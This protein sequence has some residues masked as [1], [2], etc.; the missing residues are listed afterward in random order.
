[1]KAAALLLSFVILADCATLRLE[2]PGRVPEDLPR[3]TWGCHRGHCATQCNLFQGVKM[4][5][6]T[7][8]IPL[9]EVVPSMDKI[10]SALARDDGRKED[11]EMGYSKKKLCTITPMIDP[12]HPD[13]GA[14]FNVK[15]VE[16][17]QSSRVSKNDLRLAST[18]C[19]DLGS[20]PN[21]LAEQAWKDTQCS[22]VEGENLCPVHQSKFKMVLRLLIRQKLNHE[23]LTLEERANLEVIS[24]E[25]TGQEG[26][27]PINKR[28]TLH[29]LADSLDNFWDDYSTVYPGKSLGTFMTENA[30]PDFKE[31]ANDVRPPPVIEDRSLDEEL[32]TRTPIDLASNV[33][34]DD[35]KRAYGEVPKKMHH[36]PALVFNRKPIGVYPLE[37]TIKVMR[38][39]VENGTQNWTETGPHLDKYLMFDREGC[40]LGERKQ[41]EE[42]DE[43]DKFVAAVLSNCT[44]WGGRR[45]RCLGNSMPL[46]V[47]G[48]NDIC[49][50]RDAEVI[51]VQQQYQDNLDMCMIYCR[52]TVGQ[53]REALR[54]LY[55]TVLYRTPFQNMDGPVTSEL[56]D[57]LAARERDSKNGRQAECWHESY[58]SYMHDTQKKVMRLAFANSEDWC[59]HDDSGTRDTVDI[60]AT[61]TD[62]YSETFSTK[63]VKMM[64]ERTTT[65]KLCVRRIPLCYS[66]TCTVQV[67]ATSLKAEVT[68]RA[69][70]AKYIIRDGKGSTHSGYFLGEKTVEI[71]FDEPGDR[72]VHGICNKAPIERKV[73]LSTREYCNE[74][75]VGP[76]GVPMNIYCKRPLLIKVTVTILLASIILHMGKSYW[77]SIMGVAG[78]LVTLWFAWP[79]VSWKFCPL[80]HCFRWRA[81]GHKCENYRC[82]RCYAIYC[83]RRRADEEA[84]SVPRERQRH[85]K[86]CENS[87]SYDSNF[88]MTINLCFDLFAYTTE[89]V[90]KIVPVSGGFV[91]GVIILNLLW[92]GADAVKTTEDHERIMAG[93]LS[94]MGNYIERLEANGYHPY[95]ARF[96]P[97]LREKI[98]SIKQEKDCATS[99]C[100]VVMTIAAK[101]QVTKGR[102]F[103]FRV[104][105]KETISGSNLSYMDVNVKMMEPYRECSYTQ[106]YYTGPAKHR[107]VSGDTCTEGCGPCLGYLR[108]RE[109]I[110]TLNYT[111]PVEHLHENSASWAC[112]GAG[113]AAINNGCT[114]GLCWCDLIE[115]EYSV[116]AL[117]GEKAFVTLCF[118]FGSEGLCKTIGAEER[119]T[120]ITVVKGGELV[121]DCPKIIACKEKT[122]ECF[123]GD[124]SGLG[125][126][127]NKFGS[128]KMVQGIISFK[129]EMRVQE[130]CLFGKHRWF[131]YRQCCKDTYHLRE[132]LDHVP[133]SIKEMK[134]GNKYILP[135]ENA[136]E[137]S[138]E[139]RLP[140]YKYMR[141][142]DKLRLTQTAI[143]SCRGCFACEEGGSCLLHYTSDFAVTPEFEC[144][145]ARTDQSHITLNRGT[146]KV[147]FNIFADERE[148]EIN[149]TIAG[150]KIVGHY[151]LVDPPRH[152]HGDGVIRMDSKRVIN[153]DCGHLFCN[154]SPFDFKFST[155]KG[156]LSTALLIVGI[157]IL[158][159][160]VY[161]SGTGIASII[162]ITLS[163]KTSMRHSKQN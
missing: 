99:V 124:I 56:E 98:E 24:K 57:R 158:V 145:G 26:S 70:Y 102:E 135:T 58:E 72:S 114:C 162:K 7:S 3:F 103:G 110:K 64:K 23:N 149:C 123:K 100:T 79:I 122:K 143:D 50:M 161:Y 108:G 35:V 107:S 83:T 150:H 37:E 136:G 104:M 101:L 112:D 148:G 127:G 67:R 131:E 120:E 9:I 92:S 75:Y 46:Y 137:W 19:K 160:V 52:V 20:V 152:P 41:L 91:T 139:M 128:V 54:P 138:L 116:K 16:S 96:T 22:T 10:C 142:S 163:A 141:S 144:E 140:P 55:R 76:S 34:G 30:S 134:E 130:Q 88:V 105:P 73:T 119:S 154:W 66:P 45:C 39:H 151:T 42:E 33:A 4:F 132:T 153:S 71:E 62:P 77:G 11:H 40:K 17:D 82:R 90:C 74:K 5:W 159:V 36:R 53:V 15:Q 8:E 147:A 38:G 117:V 63:H 47:E 51:E 68:M 44:K 97:G 113:C 118:Q 61:C 86:A 2:P 121:N 31:D 125:D 59:L 94:D 60:P 81:R 14:Y 155:I 28:Y 49:L 87:K 126:F 146:N 89:W 157:V 25:Q 80:C 95:N 13:E 32:T 27:V 156:Y 21:R 109:E 133:F 12:Q 43:R 29:N 18:W 111:K 106:M 84:V 65:W 129:E 1:M 93:A 6:D 48:S 78:T 85:D 69:S 115:P